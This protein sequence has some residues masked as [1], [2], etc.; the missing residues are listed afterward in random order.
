MRCALK[1]FPS[2]HRHFF[3]LPS[4]LFLA[5]NKKEKKNAVQNIPQ[6]R[7]SDG[8]DTAAPLSHSPG[9]VARRQGLLQL[10]VRTCTHLHFDSVQVQ[11]RPRGSSHLRLCSFFTPLAPPHQ[12]NPCVCLCVFVSDSV[13]RQP[14][15]RLVF[16]WEGGGD[17]GPG[18]WCSKQ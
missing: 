12:P 8:E 3:F 7:C 1:I 2:S 18:T 4:L 13:V 6:P 9:A 10:D 5:A 16:F 11:V 15:S 17:G 14:G